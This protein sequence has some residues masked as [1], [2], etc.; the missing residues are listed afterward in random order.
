MRKSDFRN[1]FEMDGEWFK[2]NFH[3]HTTVSDGDLSPEEQVARYAEAGY[4]ILNLSDHRKTSDVSLLN[5]SANILVVSGMECHPEC[6]GGTGIYHIVAVN[7]P[8]GFEYDE[9]DAVDCVDRICEAGGAA[10]LAHPHWNDHDFSEIIRLD[11]CVALEVYNSS[12]EWSG[13]AYSESEW[14]TCFRHEH[15]IGAVAADDTHCG[16]KWEDRTECDYYDHFMGWT[17]M[18]MAELTPEALVE[19]LKTGA[20]YASC[21]P[22]IKDF[23][24]EGDFVML[25]CSP[26]ERVNFLALSHGYGCRRWAVGDELITELKVPLVE[27]NMKDWPYIRCF[28]TDARGRKAWTNPVFL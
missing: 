1:P 11:R 18:R 13:R 10:I 4:K 16:A 15:Y 22:V 3:T 20:Y 17:W 2:A 19:S 28:V 12:C 8:H 6:P 5:E 21:G 9:K 27:K 23:R 7:I 26:V 24:V 25:K 14:D